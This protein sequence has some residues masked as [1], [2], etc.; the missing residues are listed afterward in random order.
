MQP[1]PM[2]P[3]HPCELTFYLMD[4]RK[5]L[6]RFDEYSLRTLRF[7]KARIKGQC[8][9]FGMQGARHLRL[10][11]RVQELGA[12]DQMRRSGDFLIACILLALTLPLMIIV[13]LAI[14]WEGPGPV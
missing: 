6:D 11:Q 14:K 2:S 3:R 7:L 9:A 1:S 5:F 12:A 4:L 13:A 10:V 8:Y